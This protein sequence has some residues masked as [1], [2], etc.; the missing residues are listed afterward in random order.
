LLVRSVK[1]EEWQTQVHSITDSFC[2]WSGQWKL[3]NDKRKCIWLQTIVVVV[4]Q[5]SWLKTLDLDL[6]P[7]GGR[8]GLLQVSDNCLGS[9]MEVLASRAGKQQRECTKINTNHQTH[10][11]RKWGTHW[12]QLGATC[13]C[14]QH[15][16]KFERHPKA[17]N[18][19]W[20]NGSNLVMKRKLDQQVARQNHKSH[21]MSLN[22]G[23]ASAMVSLC[24]V[25]SVIGARGSTG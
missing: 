13:G 10:A 25:Y 12:A 14:I 4:G 17:S 23:V 20:T 19:T 15:N 24:F 18:S 11:A 7:F 3:K 8:A 2:C 22:R 1:T 16:H 21:N 6:Q 9:Q 5:P